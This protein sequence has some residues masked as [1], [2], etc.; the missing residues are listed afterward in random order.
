MTE[1]EREIADT[2]AATIIIVG[3]LMLIVLPFINI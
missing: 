2:V 1:R 3:L